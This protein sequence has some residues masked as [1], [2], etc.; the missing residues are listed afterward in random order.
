[1][2]ATEVLAEPVKLRCG[3]VLP[4]RLGKAALSEQLASREGLPTVELLRL[5][6]AWADGGAGLLIT[7]NIMVDPTALGEPRNVAIPAA[8]DP[9]P[10]RAWART[11]GVAGTPLWVQ[12]NHPGRQTPRFLSKQPVAPSAV[13]LDVGVGGF[14][15]PPRELT[16]AQI[17]ALVERYA[18]SARVLVEAGFTGVQLHGAH[19]YLIS[20]FLSPLTNRRTDAWGGDAARRRRFLLEIVRAVRAEIGDAVPLSVKLNSA[21][22]QRGGFTEEESLD[23]VRELDNAGIDLVEVSGGT[24]EQAAMMG[25]AK[26]STVR[27]EAYFLEYA[28]KVR[29]IS[30]VTLMVTGGF[31]TAEGMAE[32]VTSGALDV[33]GFGRPMTLRPDL[34]A[35][36]LAGE[37]VEAQRPAPSTGWQPADSWLQLQWYCQQMHLLAA[38]K[39]PQPS[40]SAARALIV[41]G[42]KDPLNA[43]R[44]VRA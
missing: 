23:V 14:F 11:V 4:N 13:P 30:E 22:F 26:N 31:R 38:G 34:P 2:G 1:M 28:R 43:F 21:D 9:E 27:R 32:A 39:R 16:G 24:Y 10:F 19:G 15:S 42:I 37:A 29:R 25:L 20:Q 6:R 40:R 3:V 8:P 35:R 18:I 36:L 41:G 5:Y 12:L 44:R 7:G 17:E 33:V